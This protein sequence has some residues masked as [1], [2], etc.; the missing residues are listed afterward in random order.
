MSAG[1]DLV[2]LTA[3]FG[4][5]MGLVLFI[6]PFLLAPKRPSPVKAAPFECGQPPSGAGRV[7]LMMQYYG[8]LL[9]FLVVEVTVLLLFAWA[10][11]YTSLGLAGVV[12]V[13]LFLGLLLVAVG[14][15]LHLTGRGELW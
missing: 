5:E 14:Y 15:G 12:P 7:R 2:L 10:L 11:S 4:L 6:I 13:A 1:L 3:L 9:L 8:Y